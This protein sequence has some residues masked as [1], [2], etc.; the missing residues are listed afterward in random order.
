MNPLPK[1]RRWREKLR[2][3]PIP[4]LRLPHV[5]V[6]P[7]CGRES[8]V[9]TK[10]NYGK[11][12]KVNCGRCGLCVVLPQRGAALEQVDYYSKFLDMWRAESDKK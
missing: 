7:R 1:D 11:F 12:V 8:I 3:G 2:R 9:I 4:R 6:C 5:F 10:D